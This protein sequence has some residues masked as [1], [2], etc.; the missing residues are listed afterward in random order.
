MFFE[1]FLDSFIPPVEEKAKQVNQ[2]TWILETTGSKDA[3]DLLAQLKV[4]YL[5]FFSDPKIYD[6]LLSW[7]KLKRN[8]PILERQ[9]TLLLLRF[10]ENMIPDELREKIAKKESLIAQ[11][12]ATFRPRFEEKPLTENQI[13]QTLKDE[14]D[15][16]L[17]KKVW[18]ASKEIGSCLAPHIVELVDLRNEAAKHLG[19]KDYFQMQLNLQEVDED[20]LFSFLEKVEKGSKRAYDELITFIEAKLQDRFEVGEEALFPWGWSDAFCQED[21]LYSQELDQLVQDEDLVSMARNFYSSMGLRVDSILARSD[22]YERENKN[23][24]AFCIHIDRNGDVRTLNNLTPSMRWAD[25][26]LHELG[27]GV[28]DQETDFS[29]P[30]LLRE[31]PHMITTEAM[32][33]LMGSQVYSVDFLKKFVGAS[34]GKEAAMKEAEKSRKRQQL[35]FSRWV[36][37]MSY[38]E[39]EL[40]RNPHQDLQKLWWTLV[41]R[42]QKVKAPYGREEKEDWASKFHIGLA[43][44]YYYSYLLGEIF[45]S[46]LKSLLKQQGQ[47]VLWTQNTGQ[48]LKE[49]LFAPANCYNWM[50]L[51][52]RVLG[53]PFSEEDWKKEFVEEKS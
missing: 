5:K 48:L 43:P 9:L 26:L 10:K 52:E 2:A 12:Y 50:E 28:Y 51:I 33:L 23:Q 30:W 8:D 37:V 11:K 41:E 18:E 7:K 25:T 44:V 22:L 36:M 42:Y 1:P 19:Y 35:I 53:H 21:P 16:A 38:F 39:R 29:L 13:R 40:Y 14:K 24:H 6:Q 34:N 17:R 15:M 47:E 31:P 46:S 49:K 3:A 20:W 27:H 32:A 4:E 45:A